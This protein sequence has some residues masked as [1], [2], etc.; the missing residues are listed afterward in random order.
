[1]APVTWL[2][3][4]EGKL[5][6]R[7]LDPGR[8]LGMSLTAATGIG[9]PKLAPPSCEMA[10]SCSEWWKMAPSQKTETGPSGPVRISDPCLPPTALLF[11]LWLKRT[12]LLQVLPPSVDRA[13]TIGSGEKAP[14]LPNLPTPWNSVQLAYTFPKKGLF[15]F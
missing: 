1:M 6:S 2:T 12:A 13:T 7:K 9:R 4:A 8:G 11:A 5:S 14:L 10:T 3:S 15:G